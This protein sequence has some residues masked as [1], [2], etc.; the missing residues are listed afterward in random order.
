MKCLSHARTVIFWDGIKL[1]SSVSSS[2]VFEED[3]WILGCLKGMNECDIFH[4]Q[5]IKNVAKYQ[6]WFFF[7]GKKRIV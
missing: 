5:A 4:L 2:E 1:F 6:N 7:F 3:C